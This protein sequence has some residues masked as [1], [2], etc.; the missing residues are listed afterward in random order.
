MNDSKPRF[1]FLLVL[2][3]LTLVLSFFVF[4]PFLYALILASVFA[5]VSQPVYK[6][7]FKFFGKQAW[8]ASL[9]TILV[10]I[11]FILIPLSLLGWQIFQEGQQLYLSLSDN[12]DS[13]SAGQI[14]SGLNSNLAKL[15]PGLDSLT[16]DFQQYAKSGL[17]FLLSHLSSIFFNLAKIVTGLFIFIVASFYLLKDGNKF[18]QFLVQVSPLTEKDDQMIINKIVKATNSVVRG[19]LMIAT[20]QGIVSSFGLFIFGVPNPILWGTM[21]AVG[22]LIPGVGTAVVLLPAIIY[23]YLSGQV[24]SA[25]GLLVWGALAVGLIDNLLSPYLVGKKAQL[26]PLLML[27]SVLGGLSFFGPIGLILGPLVISLLLVLLEIYST[28]TTK[29]C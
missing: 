25:G 27:L 23:L 1:Y 12:F 10:A 3:A 17:S 19:S 15:I 18:R 2:L 22:A 29:A 14:F 5:L 7:I 11:V 9:L 20:L 21:A 24:I 8:L 4:R 26:H 6:V 28:I 13:Q 16:F